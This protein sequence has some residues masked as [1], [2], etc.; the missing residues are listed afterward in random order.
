[1]KTLILNGSPHP[2]G[3]TAALLRA[4]K[5]RLSGEITQ[6]DCYRASISPCVD[7]RYCTT[8]S[9][10]A[11]KDDMQ[12]IYPVIEECDCVVVA[13]PV[14]FSLPTPPVLS[15]CSR[16]QT[17]FC[18]SYF[19]NSPAEIRPKRG[20]ILLTGGG[21]GSAAPA[22]SA[23]RR[24]LRAVRC[25]EI[26]PAVASLNTDRLPAWEDEKALDAARWLADFLNA[27]AESHS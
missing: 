22:E 18:Q 7:C 20:G 24:L 15:V 3:D 13:T 4:L 12:R 2:N 14:Y 26:A 19:Q 16:L 17:Y 21:N 10:C 5:E 27:C 1:M 11:Q 8:H 6:V 25:V 9:G 23:I